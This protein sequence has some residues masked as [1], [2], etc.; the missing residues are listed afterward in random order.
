MA[1]GFRGCGRWAWHGF[2][3]LLWMVKRVMSPGLVA[4]VDRW[5]GTWAT[6]STST[7]RMPRTPTIRVSQDARIV[8]ASVDTYLRFAEAVNRLDIADQQPG[9]PELVGDAVQSGAK[10]KV[11]GAM[12]AVAEKIKR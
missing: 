12:D 9:I 6:C 5:I 7:S 2:A 11:A 3:F 10:R 1:P 4:L 8:I